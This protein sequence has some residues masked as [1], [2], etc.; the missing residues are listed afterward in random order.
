MSGA[1]P[2]RRAARHG[3]ALPAA[4]VLPAQAFVLGWI[5]RVLPAACAASY[6]RGSVGYKN[7]LGVEVVSPWLDVGFVNT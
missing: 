2:R 3:F 1:T 5:D 6:A 7:P 4:A